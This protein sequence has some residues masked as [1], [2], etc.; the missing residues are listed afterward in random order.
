MRDFLF[1]LGT[2]SLGM[3]VFAVIGSLVLITSSQYKNYDQA[4]PLLDWSMGLLKASLP[5]IVLFL[6][7][8]LIGERF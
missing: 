8:F 5:L 3:A 4:E 6:G 2:S 1:A 7:C